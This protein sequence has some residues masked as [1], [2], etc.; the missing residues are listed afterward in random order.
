M[1]E[2][3]VRSHRGWKFVGVVL[4]A[5]GAI[6]TASLR[7]Q[8]RKEVTNLA[9]A[10][11]VEMARPPVGPDVASTCAPASNAISA[12]D[13][14]E[15]A[16][17]GESA[18]G[19]PDG[20]AECLDDIDADPA[21]PEAARND[22]L[23]E[24][25]SYA[26]GRD[27]DEP[28]VA[29]ARGL[30][31]VTDLPIDPMPLGEESE[32][33]RE[34]SPNPLTSPLTMPW[35]GRSRLRGWAELHTHMFAELAWP[36][37]PGLGSAFIEGTVEGPMSVAVRRCTGLFDHATIKAGYGTGLG[38]VSESLTT[39]GKASSGDTG[40]HLLRRNGFD[41][42]IC[43]YACLGSAPCFAHLNEAACLAA[44]PGYCQDDVPSNIS[45]SAAIACNTKL[46]R[47]SCQGSGYC[48]ARNAS[49]WSV[50]D[51]LSP[52]W[53]QWPNCDAGDMCLKRDP[54]KSLTCGDL[55]QGECN[56]H[57]T[58]CNWH[59]ECKHVA[60][61]L[62]C[63]DLNHSECDNHS[64]CHWSNFWG[65]CK[66][67]SGM[68]ECN[69]LNSTECSNHWECQWQ[70]E[71]K[72]D[73]LSFNPLECSD[74]SVAECA[75]HHG[76]GCGERDCVQEFCQWHEW[77]ACHWDNIWP[78]NCGKHFKDWPAWDTPTHQ[79][80]WWGWVQDAY[81]R[82]L[83]VL[84]VSILDAH[85]LS[86]LFPTY[87][88]V[89]HDV[90]LDQIQ[91]AHQFVANHPWAE[92]AL[93]PAHARQI[94]R[95]GRL[96]I[97]LTLE[98]EYPFCTQEP[99][100]QGSDEEDITNITTTLD[101]YHGL[102]VRA[103][104]IVGHFDN[105]YGGVAN[106]VAAIH[107]IQWMYQQM[108]ADGDITWPEVLA[109]TPTPLA[110]AGIDAALGTLFSPFG[111]SVPGPVA[112]QYPAI[113][114]QSINDVHSLVTV[115]AKIAGNQCKDRVTGVDRGCAECLDENN[116]IACDNK[117]GVWPL[118]L[119]LVQALVDRHMLIDLAHLS[120]LGTKN[121]DDYLNTVPNGDRYPL[122]VSHGDPR[123]A[124][125]EPKDHDGKG[126]HKGPHQEKPTPPEIFA[127]IKKRGG[128]FG[129][130]TGPDEFVTRASSG[131][132]N[133]C[134]GSSKSFAQSLA[135]VVDQ[136]V[137]VGFAVDMNG[138]IQNAA[139]RFH[140]K[141][142][143]SRK[144]ACL[145]NTWQQSLQGTE[146]VDDPSTPFTNESEYNTKGLGHIGFLGA[147]MDDLRNVG[148][149]TPYRRALDFGA[150]NFIRM[151]E[152]AQ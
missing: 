93:T 144:A 152:R 16:S 89:P 96:A 98:A 101:E 5:A 57:S 11:A 42:R 85:P 14:R 97:V 56:A 134:A 44:D 55:N 63:N 92:I 137:G 59:S 17:Y 40:L 7:A 135:Y 145:Y 136:G 19:Y 35:M 76:D 31:E 106:Y 126:G 36:Q 26:G 81:R 48:G 22:E 41:D 80:H 45:V 94:V 21:D 58:E 148:L 86:K 12:D 114:F 47:A 149:A 111:Q 50:A 131:V 125:K 18:R 73:A 60:G 146:V 2:R 151:W 30:D 143:R 100:G 147:F 32:D 127:M 43:T 13:A 49:L 112:A 90:I 118:G 84:G 123:E 110:L 38:I 78:P 121:I 23:L 67:D 99:C 139:P 138:M 79:Q 109:A 71:C 62:E 24:W 102:G 28:T 142:K 51:D 83:R 108:T 140:T 119:Q 116:P 124:L 8:D 82:G 72:W 52:C 9:A 68:L 4:V 53:A 3:G 130:R 33:G 120:D 64:E 105:S 6:A 61:S 133:D 122:Y 29:L 25:E 20:L 34:Q 39:L 27:L 77:A 128:V 46:T 103:M 95:S 74:L 87:A 150:E 91:A 115:L 132:A 141:K 54:L 88:R 75:N 117:I 70:N 1:F 107:G 69:D 104:Q 129:V 37:N 113:G 66:W 65:S 10:D 15:L